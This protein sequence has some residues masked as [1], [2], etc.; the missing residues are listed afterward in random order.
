MLSILEVLPWKI[1]GV[2]ALIAAAFV[3]GCQ[4]G[5]A[6]VNTAWDSERT[7]AARLAGKIEVKQAQTTTKV[8]TEYVDRVKVVRERGQDIVKEVSVYVSSDSACDLS[9]GFRLLHDAAATRG[10]LP[11]PARIADAPAATAQEVATTV[12]DNYA[13]YHEVAEQLMA[14]QTWVSQQEKNQ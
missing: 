14:L 6:T 10:E 2:I 1:L 7:E 8:V 3:G 13:T 11:D 4:H 5:K 9:G 12:A